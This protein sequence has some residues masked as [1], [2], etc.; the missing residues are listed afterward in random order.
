MTER[1]LHWAPER[2]RRVA[3]SLMAGMVQI[4]GAP[5]NITGPFGGVGRSGIGRE[6]GKWGIEEYLEIKAINGWLI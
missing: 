4:N 1:T 5:R 3:R 2:A 6:G